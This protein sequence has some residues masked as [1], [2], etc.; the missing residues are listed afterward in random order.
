MKFSAKRN[1]LPSKRIDLLMIDKAI[2]AYHMWL[3]WYPG[4]IEGAVAAASD[5]LDTTEHV[6]AFQ[7]ALEAINT[8]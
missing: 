4:D 7:K 6:D 3:G 8:N 1:P 2:E 5:W